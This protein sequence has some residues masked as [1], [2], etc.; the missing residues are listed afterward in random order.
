MISLDVI[1]NALSAGIQMMYDA[2]QR[3]TQADQDCSF[4]QDHYSLQAHE[5]LWRIFPVLDRADLNLLDSLSWE[6]GDRLDYT[7][8]LKNAREEQRVLHNRC[9]AWEAT[10]GRSENIEALVRQMD[11]LAPA[12]RRMSAS[13]D[14]PDAGIVMHE[15]SGNLSRHL[16]DFQTWSNSLRTDTDL[17]DAVYLS[18]FAEAS[19]PSYIR[20]LKNA[21]GPASVGD[22]EDHLRQHRAFSVIRHHIDIELFTAD[23]IM[24]QLGDL[25]T[26]VRAAVPLVTAI[27]LQSSCDDLFGRLNQ[28]HRRIENT[29][30]VA[31]RMATSFDRRLDPQNP[32]SPFITLQLAQITGALPDY[33]AKGARDGG[34][35]CAFDLAATARLMGDR[36]DDDAVAHSVADLRRQIGRV[37]RCIQTQDAAQ[38]PISAPSIVTLNP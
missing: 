9:A 5:I 13:D 22:L 25:Q 7:G 37:V 12:F 35:R 1:D 2:R 19:K 32:E 38:T 23:Q 4:A 27:A 11:Q 17:R 14:V 29:G 33:T 24:V 21:V 15:L 16:M 31:M 10:F 20:S 28:V 36:S 26:D 34:P 8:F 18:V 6:A 3:L 30:M